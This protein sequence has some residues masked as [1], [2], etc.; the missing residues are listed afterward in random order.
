MPENSTNDEKARIIIK[1]K[2][3]ESP[4]SLIAFLAGIKAENATEHWIINSISVKVATKY[5]EDIMKRPEVEKVWRDE[6][7]HAYPRE[8]MGIC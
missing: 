1:L 8:E 2:N 3:G 4:E 5:I 7:V 6:K